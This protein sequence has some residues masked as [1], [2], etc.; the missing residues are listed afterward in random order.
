MCLGKINSWDLFYMAGAAHEQDRVGS[1]V[2]GDSFGIWGFML[3]RDEFC[4]LLHRLCEDIARV[5]LLFFMT[6]SPMECSYTLR[7]ML[8]PPSPT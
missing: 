5:M 8:T 7:T 6:F 1:S 2:A 4:R 3:T